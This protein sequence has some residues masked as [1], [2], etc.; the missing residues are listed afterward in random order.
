V[1]INRQVVSTGGPAAPTEVADE[2]AKLGELRDKGLL[3]DEEF[4][5]QKQKLLRL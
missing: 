2:I 4:Q 5:A 3:T 1:T